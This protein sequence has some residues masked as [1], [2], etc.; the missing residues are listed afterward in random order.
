MGSCAASST[1]SSSSASAS[2][3]ATSSPEADSDRQARAL[4]SVPFAPSSSLSLVTWNAQALFGSVHGEHRIITNKCK[5]LHR[6]TKQHDIVVIQ[7]Y[8]GDATDTDTLI[9]KLPYHRVFPS[10]CPSAAA[11]GCPT[12]VRERVCDMLKQLWLEEVV[13]GRLT[14]LHTRS[15]EQAMAAASVH[16]DPTLPFSHKKAFLQQLNRRLPPPTR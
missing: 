6:L 9:R 3:A 4:R 2:T 10:Y 13:H 8:H 1:P 7:E 14:T 5:Q 11:G 16:L 15:C 12:I